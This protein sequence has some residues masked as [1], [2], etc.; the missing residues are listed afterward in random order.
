MFKYFTIFSID[1]LTTNDDNNDDV[2]DIID[3][4]DVDM[5]NKTSSLTLDYK[6]VLGYSWLTKPRVRLSM[7]YPA[8][9]DDKDSSLRVIKVIKSV[10]SNKNASCLVKIQDV[11]VVGLDFKLT[12]DEDVD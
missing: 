7:E 4:D 5:E 11:G 3:A 1:S 2:S 12:H 10:N 6:P 9:Q 8:T